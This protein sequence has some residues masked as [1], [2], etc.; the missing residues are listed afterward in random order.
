MSSFKGDQGRTRHRPHEYLARRAAQPFNPNV[1]AAVH[2][3]NERVQPKAAKPRSG[4]GALFR[5]LQLRAAPR[6]AQTTP[7]VAAGIAGEPW[8]V[9]QLIEATTAYHVRHQPTA[10]D[11]FIDTL[12]DDEYSNESVSK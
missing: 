4:L 1:P 10:F 7:A 11:R 3:D 6:H 8:T 2:T 5:S 9:E 12:P